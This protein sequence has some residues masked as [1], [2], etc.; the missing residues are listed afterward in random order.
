LK[1][2]TKL[3]DEI[4][5]GEVKV[6]NFMSLDDRVR[7]INNFKKTQLPDRTTRADTAAPLSEAPDKPRTKHTASHGKEKR[8]SAARSKLIPAEFLIAIETPR[9]NDIYLELKRKLR[10][11]D[12]PN[13]VGVLFRVF[14]ELSVD[15]YMDRNSLKPGKDKSLAGKVLTVADSMLVSGLMSEK[16]AIPV[17]EAVKSD[18][19]LTL[20]TNLNALV[21]N[22]DMMVGGNDLKAIWSRMAPFVE[23]LWT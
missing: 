3:V 5:T 19:K 18:D 12:V 21:H 1:G 11:D 7:Y 2:L 10:V 13:A 17:R 8:H 6:K 22:R 4:G 14:L 20:A 23:K 15:A 9:I 16:Q